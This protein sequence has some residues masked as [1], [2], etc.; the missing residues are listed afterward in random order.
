MRLVAVGLV[1]TLS[2]CASGRDLVR[3]GEGAFAARDYLHTAWETLTQAE[4][5]TEGHRI[6][7]QLETRAALEALG[8]P[9]TARRVPYQGPPTLAVAMA[10]LERSAPQV[11]QDSPAQAHTRRALAELREAL[12]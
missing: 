8:G 1:L 12:R 3:F 5:D 9:A 2:A 10:L 4:T 6:R 7:A 11:P